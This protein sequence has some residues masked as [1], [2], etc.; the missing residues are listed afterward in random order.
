LN[1]QSIIP[2]LYSSDV[3]ASIR[4]YTEVLGF[5]NSWTWDEPAGFGGVDLADVRIYFCKDGQGHP[6]T[7]LAINI[8]D[9]DAYHKLI[10]SRG[11]QIINP[12]ES[13]PWGMREMLVADPDGHRIR[14]G[15]GISMHGKSEPRMPDNI[16]IVPGAPSVDQLESLI[17][18]VGWHQ[19]PGQRA[20]VGNSAT[21][22]HSVIAKKRD[23]GEVIGCAFLFSDSAGF[24][25][26][27]NVI[28]RPEWQAKLIGT[29]LLKHIN[30][31]LE[32]NAPEHSTVALHTG[33]NLAHFYRR[34]GFSTSFSM[35][36]TILRSK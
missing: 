33:P 30:D 13:Y 23:N 14:F 1:F 15:Q 28:V 35:Q 10:S 27:K 22:A 17:R 7:W 18:S 8:D 24:Y 25:Y 31:W 2:I 20:G 29:A 11:A 36:K 34:F 6:G 12:P 4:Y 26:I 16:D 3:V 19:P 21:I 5:K 32:Q 9:V